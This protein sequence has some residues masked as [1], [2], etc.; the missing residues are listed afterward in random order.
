MTTDNKTLADVQP[1]GRVRLGNGLPEA[2]AQALA[3]VNE[4][5]NDA[6]HAGNYKVANALVAARVTLSKQLLALSA[7]PSPGGQGDA[8]TDE[9][10]DAACRAYYDTAEDAVAVDHACMEAALR[11]ALA[12]RQ[13]VGEPIGWYTDDHLTDRSAT[14][15]D[16]AVADR[17]R[18]KGWPVS[19][20]YAA[21]PAQ[22]PA[23]V[24]LDGLDRALG[25][26]ID[27]RDRYHE[28]AD[29][30]AGHIAAITGVDIGEHS[31][32]NCPW[33]NAIEAAEEYKP[34]QAV[35]LP[36]SLDADPAGIRARV[37]DVITGTLMVGAQGHTPPPVGHWAEPFWQAARADAKAQAVDLVQDDSEALLH[38]KTA[39]KPVSQP[40]EE[41]VEQYVQWHDEGRRVMRRADRG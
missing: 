17:W 38:I 1:G 6:R 40:S 3:T 5:A 9:M 34:A 25:E 11:A 14:T 16:R 27:Q 8:V 31:S 7:Q 39:P 22:Q 24:Y 33:Q 41:W 30:L 29:D 18:A 35:D 13:P 21:P 19:P 15:Y 32:A 2:V 36:Y 12:A 26:A 37:A 20:L 10:V 28:V 23:Q 4:A